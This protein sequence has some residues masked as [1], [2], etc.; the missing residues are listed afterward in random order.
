MD[1]LPADLGRLVSAV[2]AAAN[3]PPDYV[4]AMALGVAAGCV[5]AAYAV[6]VKDGYPEPSSLYVAVVAR[7]GDGKS[8]ALGYLME[9]L[10]DEQAKR[11]REG[12]K[13]PAFVDDVTVEKMAALLQQEPRGLLM[14][15]DE[16]AALFA[17]FNQ[18]KAKGQG[19]DR[20]FYLKAHSGSPHAVERKDPHADPV[21][22]AHPCLSVVGGIQPRVLARYTEDA[23]DGLFDRFL[24]AW[25]DPL[26]MAAENGLT[27][28]APLREAWA[29][30]VGEL[31]RL[32]PVGEEDRAKRPYFLKLDP[33]AWDVWVEWTAWL[34]AA[35]NSEEFPDELRGPAAKLRGIAARLALVSHALRDAYGEGLARRIGEESMRRGVGL[36]KYFFGHARRV[37]RATGREE[38]LRAARKVLGF[39]RRWE[40]ATFTRRDAWRA[41]HGSFDTPDD[42]AAPLKLLVQH[43]HL[44]Y[45]AAEYAGTGRRGTTNYEKHPSLSDTAQK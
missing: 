11:R 3:S 5:G 15:R 12:L 1:L 45:A 2:G 35:V 8:P 40:A 30:A 14:I 27:V 26:P 6:D 23:D 4:G 44:R 7:K 42:L 29:A 19:A 41:L 33:G 17:G 20:T 18:Y 38:G 10:V 34:A 16:L 25:P 39:A 32:A 31:R 37:W 13:V 21:F 22:V 43:G 36:A 24:F 9:P 28:P